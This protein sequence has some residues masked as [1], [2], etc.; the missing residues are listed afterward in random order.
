M[1]PTWVKHKRANAPEMKRIRRMKLEK[2]LETYSDMPQKTQGVSVVLDKVS[3]E[4]IRE[5]KR[6]NVEIGWLVR[7]RVGYK[8]DIVVGRKN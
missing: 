6:R 2:I 5:Y 3:C 1:S 7:H 4:F 8:K